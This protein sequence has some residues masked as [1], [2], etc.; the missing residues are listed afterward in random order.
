MVKSDTRIVVL[1]D[2]QQVLVEYA[3]YPPDGAALVKAL[4][5]P[6]HKAVILLHGGASDMSPAAIVGVRRLI[7]KLAQVVAEENIIVIDGGTQ[8]GV[9]AMMGEAHAAAGA[10]SPLIGVCP[11]ELV[12][13]PGE[14]AEPGLI[15]L[16]PNHTHFV[17]TAGNR[18]GDETE[19]MFALADAL[20]VTTP[21]LAILMNG[22]SVAKK[23]MLFNVRRGRDIIVIRGSG[24]LADI[25]AAVACGESLPQDEDMAF[26]LQKGHITMLDVHEDPEMLAFLIRQK[27]FKE[28]SGK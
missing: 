1:P 16:E 10:R 19:T 20:S 21:S 15:P 26:I 2:N 6:S 14:P 9:M 11:A 28:N 23:E 7:E 18:W 17:L 24:R 22:G 27:L 5:L 4:N 12:A 13:R 8:A 25:I 3:S